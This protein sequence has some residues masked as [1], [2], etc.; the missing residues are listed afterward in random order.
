MVNYLTDDPWNPSSTSR[1][2]RE[3][4]CA[5]DII[6]SPRRANLA[7]LAAHGCKDVRYLP[8]GYDPAFHFRE[9]AKES[10]EA[11][12]F[13]ADV[14]FIGGADRDRIPY[15]KALTKPGF[16]SPCTGLTGS[17]LGHASALA[18]LC[19]L[20]DSSRCNGFGQDITLPRAAFES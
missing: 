6:Y 18:R 9:K 17:E 5:Y 20:E 7:D 3:S 2:F 11:L 14:V 10:D 1:W 12:G 15:A 13:S 19:R 8:F 16:L 4:L